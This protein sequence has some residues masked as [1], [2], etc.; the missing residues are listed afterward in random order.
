MRNFSKNIYFPT[1]I[2]EGTFLIQVSK[3]STCHPDQYDAYPLSG[4]IPLL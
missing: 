1:K 2:R 3:V 4:L